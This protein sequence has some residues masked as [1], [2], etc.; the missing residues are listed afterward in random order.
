MYI[1]DITADL[2]SN[3]FIYADDTILFQIV[4]D[5]DV[6]AKNI[7]DDL[8]IISVWSKKWLVSMNP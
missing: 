5:V 4:D 1:N 2:D 8:K 6:S 7:N 3:P